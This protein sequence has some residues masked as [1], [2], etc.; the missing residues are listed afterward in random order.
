MNSRPHEV[1][2]VLGNMDLIGQLASEAWWVRNLYRPPEYQVTIVTLPLSFRPMTNT[3]VYEFCMRGIRLVHST[4]HGSVPFSSYYESKIQTVQQ[5]DRD[6]TYLRVNGMKLKN[7]FV[8]RFREGQELLYFQLS[9]EDHQKGRQL[10]RA[11]GIPDGAPIVTLHVRE[12]ATKPKK[13]YHNY[14]D[15]DIANYLPTIQY[16]LS[17]GYT[18]VRLGDPSLKRLPPM[19]PRL[20]DAPFHPAYN[21]WVDLYFVACSQFYVGVPSG[22]YSVANIF[23]IPVVLTN[24]T[25]TGDDWGKIGDLYIPKKF[26]SHRLGRMLSYQEIACSPLINFYKAQEFEQAGIEL[27]ENSPE[28][29]LGAVVEMDQRICQTYPADEQAIS[30][31]MNRKFKAIQRQAHSI[32]LMAREEPFNFMMFWSGAMLGCHFACTNSYFLAAPQPTRVPDSVNRSET[33]Q[34]EGISIV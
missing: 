15:A 2:Y 16:L 1:V 26:Y 10:R 32:R 18:V 25:I 12:A 17:R 3:A 19:G 34:T 23:N 31:G 33:V 14:R 24:A 6:V 13:T 21:H 11:M 28:E 30:R 29:I 7:E 5:A 8:K 4:T 27:I 9:P 22:P 20:I